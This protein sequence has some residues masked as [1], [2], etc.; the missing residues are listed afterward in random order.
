MA[1]EGMA[2][3]GMATEGV[4]TEGVATEGVATEGV[5]EGVHPIL[6]SALP[7][8]A[9]RSRTKEALVCAHAAQTLT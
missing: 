1:T 8:P 3:E 4:A 2:T 9:T 7:P 5:A 6:T